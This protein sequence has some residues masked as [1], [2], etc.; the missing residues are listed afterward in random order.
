MQSCLLASYNIRLYDIDHV[1]S[2]SPAVSSKFYIS[3][4]PLLSLRGN[5]WTRHAAQS[6]GIETQGNRAKNI[7]LVTFL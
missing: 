3:V 1:H 5:K 7:K 4:F 6:V 2:A